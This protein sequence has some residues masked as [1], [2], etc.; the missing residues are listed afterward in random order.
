VST[1]PSPTREREEAI[2]N[3]ETGQSALEVLYTRLDDAQ[4]EQSATIGGGSWSAK[5]LLGHVAAWEERALQT[6]EAWRGE[7]TLP[8]E[9]DWP[10]TDIFNARVQEHTSGQL[11]AD[12][13]QH[14][15]DIHR[16]FVEAMRTLS[17]D[18]WRS[19]RGGKSLGEALGGI[20]GGPA[21]NFRHAFDHL[22]DL[23]AYVGRS[24]AS[25]G[26]D[27]DRLG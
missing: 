16:A 5:D 9:S 11:L 4:M 19:T 17:D 22:D 3:L 14:A 7:K 21:G 1:F 20:T 13:R 24:G 25:S 8:S 26:R 27:V 23:A 2:R 6:L 18:E 15:A 10:G 12:V